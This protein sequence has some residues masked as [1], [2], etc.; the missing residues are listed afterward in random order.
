MNSA[1]RKRSTLKCT[2]QAALL[3]L[4]LLA[5]GLRLVGLTSLGLE[6]DEVANWLIDR[7]ILAGNH[8]IYFQEAYGHEA[9]F[10]YLQTL[11]VAL[12]GDN[13]LALRL[14]AALLGVLIVAVSHRLVKT[15]Y[16]HPVAFVA[17]AIVAITF[18][19]AFYSRL[20]LRAIMLPVFSGLAGYCF[21]VGM[22]ARGT[23]R[24]DSG[25]VGKGG[26][27]EQKQAAVYHS[28]FTIYHLPFLLSAILAGLSAYTYMASRV[29]PIFF[30]LYFSVMFIWTLRKQKSNLAET[31]KWAA[32]WFAVYAIVAGPLFIWLQLN[33]GSEFRISEINQPLEALLSG[34]PLPA[35]ENAWKIFGVW[36]W[37]GDPLWR[38]NVAGAPIF[39][40]LTAILFYAGVAWMLW[41]RRWA[42]WFVLLWIAT[43]TI[44][45]IVTAD[46]PSTI[47]MINMLPV[48][49]VPIG[50]VMH[51]LSTISPKKAELST[52]FRS[53]PWITALTLVVLL[54]SGRT[55]H[56]LHNVWPTGGDVPFVWQTAL[57]SGARWLDEQPDALPTTILGWSADTM[58]PPTMELALGR[59]DVPL[60][61]AGQDTGVAALVLP[62]GD[63]EAV[64]VIRP[65]N[66]P[67]NLA[68]SLATLLERGDS[69]RQPDFAAYTLSLADDG[70]LLSSYAAPFGNELTLKTL[71]RC[72]TDVDPCTFN[73]V[74][75]I[76]SPSDEP[77][78][79]FIHA[80]DANGNI[81]TQSDVQLPAPS[82]WQQGDHLI[83]AHTLAASD[84]AALRI[85]IYNPQTGL[86]LPTADGDSLL[87]TIEN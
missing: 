40:P 25:Q 65:N 60:R 47:R 14:P 13:A 73:T 3:G 58:D 31:V 53:N 67:I 38:Q 50:V 9:G 87:L 18:F 68:P 66:P 79:I 43:A 72:A 7:S 82:H 69:V 12:I 45:S 6:H 16:N 22:G 17:A 19:P 84:F 56:L 59:D 23:L 78:T 63:G 28:P 8:G 70:A 74:W 81:I 44:P 1:A 15:L 29:V 85:G 57:T 52:V 21:W 86:R 11:T 61:F 32:Q 34:N 26:G 83:A 39:N 41:R 64:R 80:L 55:V 51:K 30:A 42:D 24:L 54:G 27:Q 49:G 37:H 2:R 48:L 35:L 71:P 62:F 10:H 77:R 75:I 20:A 4:L 46:A 36:G 5:A 76:N 33:P